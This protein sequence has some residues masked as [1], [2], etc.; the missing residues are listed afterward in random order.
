M[1]KSTLRALELLRKKNQID[2]TSAQQAVSERQACID[3]QQRVL[4]SLTEM[5]ATQ[6]DPT[7]HD[8]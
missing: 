1:N 4:L 5:K 3:E 6:A 8:Q 2:I 7:T